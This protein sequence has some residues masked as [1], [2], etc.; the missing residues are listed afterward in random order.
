MSESLSVQV[1]PLVLLNLSDHLTRQKYR[2]KDPEV[3]VIGLVLGRQSGRM[4]EVVNTIE[5]KYKALTSKGA[6]GDIEID[7]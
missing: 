2:Q 1:H 6:A 3:R 4:L 7:E 5:I